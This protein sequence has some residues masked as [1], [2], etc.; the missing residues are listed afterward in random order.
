MKPLNLGLEQDR[1]RKHSHWLVTI[2]YQDNEKFGRVYTDM[3]NAEQF[4]ARQERSPV[5][6]SATISQIKP[7][8]NCAV[9]SS[10]T[11]IS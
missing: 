1:R 6:K 3:E 11:R 4:A 10:V 5:V 2:S 7:H 9:M 8:L